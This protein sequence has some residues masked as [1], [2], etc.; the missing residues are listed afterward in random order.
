MRKREWKSSNASRTRQN[1]TKKTG[2]NRSIAS[3]HISDLKFK[4][5]RRSQDFEGHILLSSAEAAPSKTSSLFRL[6]KKEVHF[7]DST[8]SKLRHSFFSC[9]EFAFRF[10]NIQPCVSK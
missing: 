4:Y 5:F 7:C 6:D 1:L 3:I 2:T 8:S 10:L 9:S